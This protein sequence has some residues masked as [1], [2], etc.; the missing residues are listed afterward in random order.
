MIRSMTAYAR[1]ERAT[2]FGELCWELR[3]VNHRY[4]EASFRLPETLRSLEPQ[5]RDLLR[6]EL[7]RGKLDCWL[8]VD[9]APSAG[10]LHVDEE[11]VAKLIGIIENLG[12]RS[13]NVAPADALELLRF[14]GVLI[15]PSHGVEDVG[16]EARALFA[17]ALE[18]LKR[19]RAREG[20]KL[21]D[22][23]RA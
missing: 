5:L 9:Y 18:D 8:R 4:L 20:E 7:G 21:A 11:L 1:T 3:S 14:P 16:P 19:H 13:R 12:Q 17:D 22:L 15:E 10:T 6:S 2:T 23:V